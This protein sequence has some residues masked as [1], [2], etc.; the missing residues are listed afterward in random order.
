MSN[1][2]PCKDASGEKCNHYGCWEDAMERELLPVVAY[3]LSDE[4]QYEEKDDVTKPSEVKVEL[5]AKGVEDVDIDVNGCD[6][7]FVIMYAIELLLINDIVC[8]RQYSSYL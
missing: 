4:P 2:W 3:D 1:K 8:E 5:T 7:V 6:D